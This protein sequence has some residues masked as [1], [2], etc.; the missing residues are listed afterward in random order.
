[1]TI[2]IIII[3]IIIMMG[4]THLVRLTQ[5]PHKGRHRHHDHQ[6]DEEHVEEKLLPMSHT[7][8]G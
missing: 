1:M 7:L 6:Q 8:V 5:T 2:I 3:I 4:K